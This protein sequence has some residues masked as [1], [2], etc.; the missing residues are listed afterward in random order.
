MEMYL[1]IILMELITLM[2]MTPSL[3]FCTA[4]I[5]MEWKRKLQGSVTVFG[6]EEMYLAC[7]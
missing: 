5:Q 4:C 3:Q 6:M 1:T 7:H 2:R